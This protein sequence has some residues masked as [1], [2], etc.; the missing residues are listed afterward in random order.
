MSP[1]VRRIV[2][3]LLLL[4]LAAFAL[5]FGRCSR[6]QSP[7]P[8]SEA[9]SAPKAAAQNANPEPAAAQAA[10][11]LTPAT[12][13]IPAQVIAGVLFRAEWTGPNNPGDYLTIVRPGSTAA[14]YQNYRETRNGPTLELT[15][16]IEAGEW[17]VRYVTVK[18]KTVLARASLTVTPSEAVLTAPDEVV[19]GAPVSIIWTGPNNAGDFITIVPRNAP[20]KQVGNY[21]DTLKGSPLI[22]NAPVEPGEAEI[23]YITGQGRKI[24]GRRNLIIT[25]P[26]VSVTAQNH[27]VAGA[28]FSVTWKGPANAGDYITVVPKATPDGQYR[29]YTDV[30]KSGTIELTAPME[31]GEAEI[32]YMTGR[33]AR[34]LARR[35]ISVRAADIS[36]QAGEQIV[37]G[38]RVDIVW[39]GPNNPGDYITIVPKS[40]PDGQYGNYVNTT[41]GSP[42]AVPAPMRPGEAEIRY[43]SGQGAKVIARRPLT[44][45]EAKIGL[46][47]PAEAAPGST[48]QLDWTGPNN[49]GDYI[50]IAPKLAKDGAAPTSVYTARGSPAKLIMPKDPGAHEIRYMSGQ[51][52]LV[53]ART[54]IEV[55]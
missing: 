16:P 32:R 25:L 49:A 51:G 11:V 20:D 14:T 8:P 2:I 41:K 31:I 47:A 54:G 52:N 15:A 53:L 38:A 18:S 27:V 9:P 13:K 7:A 37:A 26:E 36:L 44:I 24:L 22:I 42:L 40:T 35:P 19:L 48:V 28:R 3:I 50:T 43:M 33:Q 39:S 21:G 12:L 17:E 6:V 10:E 29:N 55:K 45:I 1:R 5:L 46:K 23:R 34:V 30:G 4:L